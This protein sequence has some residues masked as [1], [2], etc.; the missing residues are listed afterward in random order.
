[1]PFPQQPA[2][3]VV[4]GDGNPAP[5]ANVQITASIAAGP[6][7]VLQNAMATTDAGGLA[8][9][10]GLTLT[11]TV[12]NY[13]LSFSAQ[14][15]A[16]VMS[17]PISLSA[18]PATQL[19]FATAPP[20]AARSRAL[21]GPVVQLQDVS[22]NPVAQS[23]IA[24]T[25]SVDLGT[26]TGGTTA[27]TG[28]EGRAAFPDLAIAG[29]PGPKTLTFNSTGLPALSAQVT[30][31]D[32]ARIEVHPATP[33]S[34]SV[35]TTLTAVPIAILKDVTGQPVA[36]APFTL[37]PVPGTVSVSPVS[38]ISGIDGTVTADAWQLGTVTG[39]QGVA[40]NVSAS[41][42]A[43]VI[44]LVGAPAA[45]AQ[46]QKTSGDSQSVASPPPADTTAALPNPLVVRVTDQYG[47]G[48]GGVIVQWRTC[49]G[50]GAYDQGTDPDGFSSSRQPI[51]PGASAGTYC[52]RAS[53]SGLS[54]I[55]FTY[56]VTASGSPMSQLRTSLPG[57]RARGLPP[58]APRPSDARRPQR[59]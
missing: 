18:G 36:D 19:A 57:S 14:G 21:L 38:G 54:P 49:D 41:V 7:G 53:A 32:V 47:N 50:A 24:I 27:N 26:L 25:A 48:V 1:L 5:Q 56:F 22:G 17:N 43:L 46:M 16:G 3:Q 59:R 13:S 44:H 23:N 15:L 29:S 40:I 8:T 2:I 42:P 34:A 37:A 4:D 35:G 52:T 58:T 33:A 31:P 51:Q 39:D 20:A 6:S 10:S 30:L 45:P 12:G 55:D 9:F 28:A 11:G